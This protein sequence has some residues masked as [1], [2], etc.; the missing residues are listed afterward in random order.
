MQGNF[1][2]DTAINALLYVLHQ[3]EGISDEHKLCKIFYYADQRHMSMYG[4]SIT[5]DSYI[6]MKYGPVP[7]S[8]LDI[9]NDIRIAGR[10]PNDAQTN[11]TE[12]FEFVGSFD[13][14]ALVKPDLDE[15]SESDMECLDYAINL[16]KDKSF[17]Q[18]TNFS[19]GEA[20]NNTPLNRKM[21]LEDI[22]KE[23]GNEPAYI[24]Y[25]LEPIHR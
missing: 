8:I 4:R 11:L 20:W 25:I 9:M 3:L 19:H 21:S 2:L 18:L 6:A 13:I 16:C 14:R 12:K 1:K 23:D 10:F 7:S 22:L 17:R 5:N 15:L 24:N